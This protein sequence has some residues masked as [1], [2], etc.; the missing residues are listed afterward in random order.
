MTVIVIA[1]GLSHERDVSLRSGRRVAQALRD[2]GLDVL[3]TDVNADLVGLIRSTDDAVVVPMLHGGLGEDG[4]LREVL[5]ILGVPFVGPT[6]ASSR[7][8]FDKAIATSVVRGAGLATP[9]Q[10]ALPHDIFR[11][12]G[13]PA[14]MEGIGAQ[15]GYPLVVKPTRSGS[16][17]GVTKVDSP[18]ALPS[19]LVAAYAYGT[20]AVVEQYLSGVEIAVTVLD[21]GDGATALPPVE[22]R[23]ESG[24]YNYESRYTA[25]ATRFV[26][27]AELPDDVLAAAGE[28]AVAAHR[29]L[30]LRHLSR[31]DMIVEPDGRPVFFEGNVAPGM[32]ETSLAPLAFEAAGLELSDVFARLVDLARG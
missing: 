29:A 14:L 24:V 7:L 30:G 25:G 31:V 22:I 3:E 20:V 28:L 10:I 17:L 13:A 23:P 16:A 4:A 15:L 9:R 21:L 18:A 8:T 12:L 32:T 26:T 11:E 5:E 19:A 6:G 27:P 1:G 2:A